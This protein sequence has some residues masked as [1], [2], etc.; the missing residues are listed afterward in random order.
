[1]GWACFMN[2]GD[3]KRKINVSRKDLKGRYHFK[4][5]RVM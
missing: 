1:M 3:D 4:N 5:T 2:G